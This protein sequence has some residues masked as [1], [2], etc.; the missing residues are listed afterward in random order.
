M[1]RSNS[2]Y[3]PLK[4]IF[5]ILEGPLANLKALETIREELILGGIYPETEEEFVTILDCLVELNQG[6]QCQTKQ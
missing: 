1:R 3:N 2:D 4:K 6:K 5:E